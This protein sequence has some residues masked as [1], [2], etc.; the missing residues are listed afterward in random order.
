V[1]DPAGNIY[2]PLPNAYGSFG[3]CNGSHICGEIVTY[4][5][6]SSGYTKPTTVISGA[7]YGPR[8]SE[9]TRG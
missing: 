4:A 9:P 1:L 5:A 6:G 3:N 8:L 7:E 2:V